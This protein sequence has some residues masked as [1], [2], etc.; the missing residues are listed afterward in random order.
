MEHRFIKYR[1]IKNLNTIW[2]AF[3]DARH[4]NINITPEQVKANFIGMLQ[5]TIENKFSLKE[6]AQIDKLS[7][8]DSES[9]SNTSINTSTEVNVSNSASTNTSNLSCSSSS[10]SSEI[11]STSCSSCSYSTSTEESS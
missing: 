3:I 7:Q 4:N 6:L 9:E 8:Y 1:K 10:N 5:H 2:K 11:S